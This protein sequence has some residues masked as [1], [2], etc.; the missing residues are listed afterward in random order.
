MKANNC[1][2]KT[3]NPTIQVGFFVE[4]KVGKI[5]FAAVYLRLTSAQFTRFQKAAM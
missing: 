5:Y 2:D 3:K 4:K 1:N